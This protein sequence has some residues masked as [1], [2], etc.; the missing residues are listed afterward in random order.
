MTPKEQ[1]E[2]FAFNNEFDLRFFTQWQI[3][4][5]KDNCTSVD[6]YLPRYKMCFIATGD[7][8]ENESLDQAFERI[9]NH[10]NYETLR[11]NSGL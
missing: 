1:I 2:D 3:R 7:W 6:L 9:L 10:F 11:Y 5:M 4:F 8:V